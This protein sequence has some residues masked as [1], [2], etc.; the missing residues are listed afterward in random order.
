[1]MRYL[2]HIVHSQDVVTKLHD[3]STQSDVKR[4][5]DTLLELG[6]GVWVDAQVCVRLLDVAFSPR[7]TVLTPLI[8]PDLT[9]QA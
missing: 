7:M 9:L 6:A 8:H 1:M 3:L 2:T 4:Q 5:Q